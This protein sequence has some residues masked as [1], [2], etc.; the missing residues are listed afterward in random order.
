MA[1]SA[2]KCTILCVEITTKMHYLGGNCVPNMC[3]LGKIPHKKCIVREIHTV[4]LMDFLSFLKK[5]TDVER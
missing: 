4:L 5:Q 1:T 2:Y 3:I